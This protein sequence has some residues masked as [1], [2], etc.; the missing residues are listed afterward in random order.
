MEDVWLDLQFS[1][2][3]L[4]DLLAGRVATTIETRAHHEPASV[5]GVAD[6]VDDR[7]VRA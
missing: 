5:G 3:S 6:E 4:G 1:K 7:L 2:V